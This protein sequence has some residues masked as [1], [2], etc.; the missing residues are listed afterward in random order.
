MSDQ[1]DQPADVQAR[2]QAIQARFAAA[3]RTT[4]VAA[5]TLNNTV[6]VDDGDNDA[7][8]ATLHQGYEEA[9]ANAVFIAAARDDIPWLLAR[10]TRT[11]LYRIVWARGR[12]TLA[13]TACGKE[14]QY[15]TGCVI[16]F[17]PYCG[18]AVTVQGEEAG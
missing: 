4:W 13:T 7:P 10:V 16:A 18:G 6:V 8:L 9:C 14:W 15:P 3:T 17:C 12:Y 1:S 11:C 2:V 5:V